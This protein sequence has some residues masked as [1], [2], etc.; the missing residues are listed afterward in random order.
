MNAAECDEWVRYHGF[1]FPR[2]AEQVAELPFRLMT[3]A[4]WRVALEE[5]SLAAAM[6]GSD[7][8]LA[9]K[10][11]KTPFEIQGHV[12]LVAMRGKEID[13]ARDRPPANYTTEPRLKCAICRDRGIVVIAHPKSD[14]LELSR[15]AVWCGCEI[16]SELDQ[17][18]AKIRDK[19]SPHAP[20]QP[21]LVFDP[22]KH[23]RWKWD[24][25][26]MRDE[27]LAIRSAGKDKANYEAGFDNWNAESPE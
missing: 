21:G 2:W 24:E 19:R 8:L 6:Q 26:A 9:G 25:P 4:S 14:Q 5:A 13:A 20:P 10:H 23:V 11:G 3:I 27:L 22:D 18:E 17:A 12:T 7:E 16:G 1:A 15:A